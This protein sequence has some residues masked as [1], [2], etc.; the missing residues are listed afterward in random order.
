MYPE[1]L[2]K[3]AAAALYGTSMFFAGFMLR[4]DDIPGWW[5]WY[6]RLNPLRYSFTAGGCGAGAGGT[7]DSTPTVGSHMAD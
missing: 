5:Y 2:A 6:S 1:S 3:R 7:F 4:F